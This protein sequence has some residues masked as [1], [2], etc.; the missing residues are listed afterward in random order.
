MLQISF[1][2]TLYA[3]HKY[4]S[5]KLHMHPSL[6]KQSDFVQNYVIIF[7]IFSRIEKKIHNAW[8]CI[9]VNHMRRSTCEDMITHCLSQINISTRN[10]MLQK[11]IKMYM[12]FGNFWHH[13][14]RQRY[15]LHQVMAYTRCATLVQEMLWIT[16]KIFI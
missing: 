13:L 10:N 6:S 2:L 4:N 5:H 8:K 3:Y 12:I 1:S 9:E 7:A 11:A 16:F 15:V 14:L